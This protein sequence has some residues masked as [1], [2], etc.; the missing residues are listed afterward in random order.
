MSDPLEG[1]LFR[2]TRRLARDH[3]GAISFALAKKSRQHFLIFSRNFIAAH[4]D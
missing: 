4:V 2:L 1:Q 3:A